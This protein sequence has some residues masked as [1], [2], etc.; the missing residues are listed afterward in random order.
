MGVKDVVFA[1]IYN[2][3]D[4]KDREEAGEVDIVHLKVGGKLDTVFSKQ[5]EII[6]LVRFTTREL[7]KSNPGRRPVVVQIDSISQVL[8]NQRRSFI[9]LE[10]FKEAGI[11]PLA[12]KIVIV[13]LGYLFQGLKDIA[14][15]T[16]MALTPGFTNQ[17]IVNLPYRSVRRPTYLLDPDMARE[18]SF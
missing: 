1:G 18:P 9:S 13:K 15:R 7:N 10:D 12:Q 17:V 6:G 14:P 11:D 3:Q 8:L 4:V 5:L 16:I 2:P